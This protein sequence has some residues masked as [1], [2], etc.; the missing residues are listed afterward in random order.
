MRNGSADKLFGPNHKV[1]A[2]VV[3]AVSRARGEL[4][5]AELRMRRAAD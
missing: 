3:G 5:K 2:A 4:G 1:G